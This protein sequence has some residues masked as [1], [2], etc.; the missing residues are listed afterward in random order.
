MNRPKTLEQAWIV[1][2]Q[3]TTEVNELRLKI[4]NRGA[5]SDILS[6]PFNF[7]LIDDVLEK[8]RHCPFRIHEIFDEWMELAGIY[9]TGKV[10]STLKQHF[11][12]LLRFNGIIICTG[13]SGRNSVWVVVPTYDYI[14]RNT[15]ELHWRTPGEVQGLYLK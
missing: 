9:E 12:K 13:G 8:H 15:N 11:S 6:I 3:L 4:A 5:A 1:I 2:A 14:L 7:H 10:R